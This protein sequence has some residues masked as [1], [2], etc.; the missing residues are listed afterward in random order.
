MLAGVMKPR[1]RSFVSLSIEINEIIRDFNQSNKS[2]HESLKKNWSSTLSTTHVPRIYV[3]QRL[4]LLHTCTSFPLFPTCGC[5][6]KP[7]THR[8]HQFLIPAPPGIGISRSALI[9]LRNIWY[10]G[11]F[12]RGYWRDPG[13]GRSRRPSRHKWHHWNLRIDMM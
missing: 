3:K 8:C 9:W 5:F 1:L 11:S 10:R 6:L 4:N 2:V 7:T 12:S 13:I